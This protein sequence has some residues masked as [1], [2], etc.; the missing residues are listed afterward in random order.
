MSPEEFWI[1]FDLKHEIQRRITKG[2]GGISEAEWDAARKKHK[3]KMNDRAVKS[4]R[5]DNR[6]QLPT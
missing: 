3:E 2:L 1:E 4:S 6:G 5:Q